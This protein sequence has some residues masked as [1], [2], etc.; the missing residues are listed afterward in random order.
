VPFQMANDD[1]GGGQNTHI[2]QS[3]DGV[4][5]TYLSEL[6]RVP[7]LWPGDGHGGCLNALFPFGQVYAGWRLSG[8]SVF[9]RAKLLLTRDGT[10]WTP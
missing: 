2:A 3:T 7:G 6:P 8:G 5:F 1:N 9:G 4:T 10:K